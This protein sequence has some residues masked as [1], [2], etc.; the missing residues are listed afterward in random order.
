MADGL[1]GLKTFAARLTPLQKILIGA[2]VVTVVVG[3]FM[4]RGGTPAASMTPLFTDLAPADA[5]SVIDELD[6]RGVAHELTDSGKTVMVPEAQVYDL[7][8]ALS[9]AG[10]PASNDGY[11][12]MDQQGI[13]TSE[14]MQRV[15]YQR[16]LEG[17]L[18]KTLRAMDGVNSATVRLALPDDSLFVDQ[19]AQPTASV[20][21]D[22][23]GMDTLSSDAVQA[24]VHLV[25]ASVKDLDPKNVTVV[26]AKGAVLS[27]PSTD[28]V[29]AGGGVSAR[30]KAEQAYEQSLATSLTAMLAKVAGSDKVSVNV[31]ATLDLNQKSAT[32]EKWGQ[33]DPNGTT[34]QPGIVANESTNTENYTG[35]GAS[36]S[37]GVLGPDGAVVAAQ[38]GSAGDTYD[39][40]STD[41]NYHVDRVVQQEV[42]APGAVTALHVAVLVDDTAVS[43][44]QVAAMTDT[45]SAAAGLDTARG[46]TIVVT[47]MPFVAAPVDETATTEAAA[48]AAAASKSQLYSM[49]RSGA[50]LFVVLIALLLGWSSARRA[51][52]VVATPIELPAL[53]AGDDDAHAAYQAGEVSMTPMHDP[54]LEAWHDE[55]HE[56]AAAATAALPAPM[57]LPRHEYQDVVDLAAQNPVEV[58]NVIR[59]WLSADLEAARQ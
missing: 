28:G 34:K 22:T 49:I 55:S 20:M 11:A 10:L 32:S 9:A 2:A 51:R 41:R 23:G 54:E 18:S 52:R 19:P 8:V 39:K 37:S 17:E 56:L 36:A 50:L 57:E 7:R 15:D 6:T 42:T 45:L 43:A 53:G 13:T 12:L 47:R 24:V 25:A 31:Q 26:D 5:Q 59:S 4:L 14:F 58:A 38:P 46:D 33:T 44:D 48:T 27:G 21:I 3:G 1:N 40:S 16:A 35:T 30:T 29:T